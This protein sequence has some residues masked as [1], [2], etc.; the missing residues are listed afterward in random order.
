M[1]DCARAGPETARILTLMWKCT[2]MGH[3]SG[4]HSMALGSF[5]SSMPSVPEVVR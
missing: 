1:L 4:L 2:L 5:W 3:P